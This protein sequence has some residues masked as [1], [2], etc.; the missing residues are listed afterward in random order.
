VQK[1]FVQAGLVALGSIIHAKY[2]DMCFRNTLTISLWSA[3]ILTLG[4]FEGFIFLPYVNAD[5]LYPLTF[6]SDVASMASPFR[7]FIAPV[8]GMFPDD[9]IVLVGKMIGA[10]R[11][12]NFVFYAGV[13]YLSVFLS[14]VFF[15]SSCRA[16]LEA[17]CISSAATLILSIFVKSQLD[18][19]SFS[20][21]APVHHAGVLPIALLVFGLLVR[22][23][24]A[25]PL[26]QSRL[27]AAALVA[28][29]VFSDIIAIVQIV[30]P[31]A[32][33]SLLL[34]LRRQLR[35]GLV[36][37][38]F[39]ITTAAVLG[40][41]AR[42]A[43]D[44][45][46]WIRL[47]MT[48]V[49]LARFGDGWLDFIRAFPS[50]AWK[51]LGPFHATVAAVGLILG[52]LAAARDVLT[53]AEWRVEVVGRILLTLAAVAAISGPVIAGSYPRMGETII[54]YQ[55]PGLILPALWLCW[56]IVSGAM[57]LR[58][59]LGRL[60]VTITVVFSALASG[61]KDL[62]R[63]RLDASD[64]LTD[65]QLQAQE[66]Q[67]IGAALIL[68]EY[69]DAKPLHNVSRLPI[70]GATRDGN[71]Y[72]WITNLGWCDNGFDEF[73]QNRG[74]V[75]IGGAQ[76]DAAEII[77]AYGHPTR[78]V[79]VGG[80]RFLIYPWSQELEERIKSSICNAYGSF[81][82]KPAYC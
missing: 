38:V 29:V 26:R 68:A 53:R 50:V 75:L 66:L 72:A 31:V 7:W 44:L 54:R 12:L 9:A 62:A 58:P 43:V 56:G 11:G 64:F 34:L 47:G 63:Y 8:N 1:Q 21:S 61:A 36:L 51:N 65:Y 25:K 71:V 67:G 13:Y 80:S 78:S 42:F 41:A 10:D 69:W 20:M 15:L 39:C 6:V 30:I 73:R 33:L 45:L 81:S 35:T 17:A 37:F 59:P 60:T 46:P 27:V 57:K 32:M 24:E 22:E 48:G 19:I 55:I 14:A 74:V 77:V 40:W 23:A 3:T 4:I 16:G 76:S 82:V 70:C 79:F 18:R 2:F 5:A 52:S 49:S 28:V